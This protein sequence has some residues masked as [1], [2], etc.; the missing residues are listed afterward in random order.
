MIR[1]TEYRTVSLRQNQFRNGIRPPLDQGCGKYHDAVLFIH[2][3]NGFRLKADGIFFQYDTKL[4]T[5]IRPVFRLHII[6]FPETRPV[7][8]GI[9]MNDD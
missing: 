1:E 4:E 8:K 7:G 3:F 2:I 9:E 6:M 5:D